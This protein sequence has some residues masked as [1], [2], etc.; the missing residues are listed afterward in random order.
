MDKGTGESNISELLCNSVLLNKKLK[1]CR[2]DT[3]A[4]SVAL[5]LTVRETRLLLSIYSHRLMILG[6]CQI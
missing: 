5:S 4:A 3:E 2:G 1:E 6:E